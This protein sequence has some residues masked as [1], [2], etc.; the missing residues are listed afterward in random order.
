MRLGPRVNV[1][2]FVGTC[3]LGSWPATA[4]CQSSVV[5]DLSQG[6]SRMATALP[7]DWSGVAVPD[8][9][10]PVTALTDSWRDQGLSGQTGFV[11]YRL[12]VAIPEALTRAA[13]PVAL[14][15]GELT[16]GNYEL[17]A[18]GRSVAEVA[19]DGSP[20][21]PRPRLIPLTAGVAGDGEVVLAIRVERSATAVAA[22]GPGMAAFA[23]L[24]LGPAD[25][26]ALRM[27]ATRLSQSRHALGTL[28]FS[29]IALL[30]GLA[31]LFLYASRTGERAYL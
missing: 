30:V 14:L 25:V 18:D 28:L 21:F 8:Q 3:L 11:W 7:A 22:G 16:Y 13:S 23:G 31:H 29:V 4:G 27:E 15:V 2:C 5:T 20:P 9:D 17:F 6:W 10:W 19:T 12:R 1:A 26:L 24:L